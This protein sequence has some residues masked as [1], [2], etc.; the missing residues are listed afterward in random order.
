MDAAGDVWH[1]SAM[2][3]AIPSWQ[4]Y[5][6][7]RAFPD[8]LHVERIVDRAAGLDWRI[9]P[10]RHAHLHQ[11]FLVQAGSAAL[12]LDGAAWS[13][14]L[15]GLL[16]LPRGVVHGFRFAA[17][18][19]GYV[20]TLPMQEFPELFGSGE[21]TAL[22]VARPFVVQADE[23]TAFEALAREH[24]A[25][26]PHRRTRLKAMA[27]LIAC[28]LL[29]LS[30]EAVPLGHSLADPRALKF[31]SMVEARFREGLSV[32]AYARALGLSPRHLNR[33]CQTGLG[34]PAGQVIEAARFRE[35]CSL[36]V[37][38]RMTV[39]SVGY[40][41]GFADPSYFTRAFQRQMGLSP[42]DYRARFEA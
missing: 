13:M 32:A 11:I 35:A 20:L 12:T 29:R 19:E 36:L 17:G 42:T 9:A 34:M 7:N 22:A 33:V 10:H 3:G 39:A 24:A 14:S 4:L 40:A 41:V 31:Q 21:D 23:G 37:Y 15:P 2:T 6:E 38:T 28:D 26:H 27:T 16:N 8:V 1:F 25:R 18:T 30:G 5:G